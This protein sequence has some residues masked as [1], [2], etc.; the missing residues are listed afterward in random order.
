[1]MKVS[2][3]EFKSGVE[4]Y[5]ELVG[6]EAIVITKDG[7]NIAQLTQAPRDKLSI[8]ES[9]CGVLPPTATLEEARAERLAKY[10]AGL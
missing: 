3:A 5:L 10:E 8:L 9:L 1:M 2:V 7:Q 6:K 4:H